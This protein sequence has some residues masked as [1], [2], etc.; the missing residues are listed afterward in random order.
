MG[1]GLIAGLITASFAL[2][3]DNYYV[4]Y[5]QDAASP[6]PANVLVMATPQGMAG[7]MNAANVQPAPR[8]L[9][10]ILPRT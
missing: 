6:A 10:G 5:N 3:D 4:C 2:A 7:S 9:S 8:A 1:L